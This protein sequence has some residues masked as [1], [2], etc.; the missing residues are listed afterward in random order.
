MKILKSLFLVGLILGL[1]VSVSWA[2]VHYT[3]VEASLLLTSIVGMVAWS[4]RNKQEKTRERNR[5]LAESKRV[6]YL[7]FLE[8]MS[9]IIGHQKE[10]SAESKEGLG[11]NPDFLD[12]FRKWSLRLTLIGSDE[13]VRSWNAARSGKYLKGANDANIALLAG[14]GLLWLEMRRDCGH[15][16]TQLEVPDVLASFVNDIENYNFDKG[17]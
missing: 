13:V 1:L 11:T 10:S 9:R 7:E 2:L 15:A 8:F 6:H 5:L 14:W 3:G 17:D 16:D 12:E 4:V